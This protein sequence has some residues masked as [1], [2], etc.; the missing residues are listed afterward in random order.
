LLT[1]GSVFFDTAIGFLTGLDSDS[2]S[3]HEAIDGDISSLEEKN[4]GHSLEPKAKGK[5][6][7]QRPGLL[8]GESN[9]DYLL[10]GTQNYAEVLGFAVE[11]SSSLGGGKSDSM[12]AFKPL[13]ERFLLKITQR[14]SQG[15]LWSFGDAGLISSSDEDATYESL[16]VNS[17]TNRKVKTRYLQSEASLL[18]TAFPGVRQLLF[19][20]LFDA[21]AGRFA[22]G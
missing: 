9:Q 16:N 22:A 6:Q 1:V 2:D 11:E 7:T 4:D 19:V 8:V 5:K 17:S 14:Y 20:P 18:Q 21:T 10:R 13:D 12:S 3:D 15:K